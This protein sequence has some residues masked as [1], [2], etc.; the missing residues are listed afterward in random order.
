M[1]S[2][3][4]TDSE[5]HDGHCEPS[6]P[7]PTQS[8]TPNVQSHEIIVASLITV[9]AHGLRQAA[10]VIYP[11]LAGR[12]INLG[13]AKL[14]AMVQACTL[15]VTVTRSRTKSSLKLKVEGGEGDSSFRKKG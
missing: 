6:R 2:N 12:R 5:L 10:V 14:F 1:P 3:R 4:L 15:I 13:D 8:L 7:S 9:C 11:G